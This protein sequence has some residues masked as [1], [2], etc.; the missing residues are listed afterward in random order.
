MSGKESDKTT[1][2]LV[3]VAQLPDVDG[4]GWLTE[5]AIRHLLFNAKSRYASN[6]DVIAGNGLEESGA[7][8]RLGRKILIDIEKFNEWV[9]AHG[10]CNSS[11]KGLDSV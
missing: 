8:I 2:R 10:N 11:I 9:R 3:T 7:I 5:P 1:S 6:G 4:Y